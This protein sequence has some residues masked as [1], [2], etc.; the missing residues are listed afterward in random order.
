MKLGDVNEDGEIDTQ[1]AGLIISYYY[2]NIELTEQQMTVADV[3]G[4]GEIDTQDAGLII[5]Y[6]YGNISQFE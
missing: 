6:Y 4:D 1:D 2:G 3:N 5:S